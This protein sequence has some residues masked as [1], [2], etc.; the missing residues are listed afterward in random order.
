MP[1]DEAALAQVQAGTIAALVAFAEA[2]VSARVIAPSVLIG[3]L[4][5]WSGAARSSELGPVG[6]MAIEALIVR[7]RA[8]TPPEEDGDP[9]ER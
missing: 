7:L 9:P 5:Q 4:E 3:H 6:Q 1:V 8:I 2:L